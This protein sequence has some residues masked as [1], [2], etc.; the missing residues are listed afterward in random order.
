LTLNVFYDFSYEALF[1]LNI[2][3]MLF[4]ATLSLFMT[5]KKINK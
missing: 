3:N 1:V 4:F 2:I 5:L